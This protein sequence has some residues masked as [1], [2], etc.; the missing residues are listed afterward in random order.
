[1]RYRSSNA[2]EALEPQLIGRVSTG[3][4]DAVTYRPM[5]PAVSS[6]GAPPWDEFDPAAYHKANYGELHPEDLQILGRVGS[7]FSDTLA[8]QTLASDALDVGSGSNLYPALLMLPFTERIMLTDVSGN[9]VQWLR[10]NVADPGV[11]DPG[12]PWDWQPFWDEVCSL[13]GYR[14]VSQ[15]R[16][17][18]RAACAPVPGVAGVEQ[19]S[20]FSLPKRK[21]QLGTMF[22][23]AESI[24][25]DPGEFRGAVRAFVSRLRQGAPFATAFMAGS[26]GYQV[27]GAS[28][29]AVPISEVDVKIL[30]TDLS[31]RELSVWQTQ[32]EEK[33]RPGYTTMIVATGIVG[34]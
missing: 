22:F 27:G 28:Y 20:V 11:T 17:Q 3:R 14:D 12:T 15:P 30:F 18:L 5:A 4:A 24:T 9:N 7:F 25:R 10:Q 21:W 13:P 29:P 1:M 8:G 32:S 23:V 2:T 31:A 16:K 26:E 34:G 33:V 6:D 19:H